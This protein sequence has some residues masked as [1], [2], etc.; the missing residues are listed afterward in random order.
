MIPIGTKIKLLND[1]DHARK[2]MIGKIVKFKDVGSQKYGIRFDI[3]FD[4]GHDLKG[5][6]ETKHGHWVAKEDF[7]IVPIIKRKFKLYVEK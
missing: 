6:C 2:N 7:K 1:V 5:G 3:P 4:G